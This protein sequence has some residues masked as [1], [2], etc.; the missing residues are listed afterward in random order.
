LI[1]VTLVGA[2]LLS[3]SI[4]PRPASASS[5]FAFNWQGSPASPRPWTPGQVNDWDLITNIAGSTDQARNPIA[6][7]GPDCSA[8]PAL[9]S[10]TN[11]ADTAFIC[12]DHMMTAISSEFDGP[13]GAIYWAPAQLADFS[14]G[15]STI[16]WQVSTLRRGERMWWDLWLTPF[17]E[18][19]VVPLQQLPAYQGPPKDAVHIQLDGTSCQNPSLIQSSALRVNVYSNFHSTDVTDAFPCLEDA[20]PTSAVTRTPFE[21]DVSRNHLKVWVPG[22]SLVYKDS[23]ISL[24]FNKAVVQWGHHSYGP[25]KGCNVPAP[26]ADTFHW[27]NV[28]ISPAAPFTMLR[29]DQPH[30]LHDGQNPTL[31][32]PQPAPANAFLRFAALLPISVSFD[33]GSMQPAKRQQQMGPDSD[34]VLHPEQFYSYWMPI[35]AGTKT[36]R[37]TGADHEAW[38]Y[39]SWWVED[40]SVWSETGSG[41][42]TSTPTASPSPAPSPSS[43][44]T[45][46]PPSC[47]TPTPA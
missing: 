30:S 7:H 8:P 31:T 11:L 47:G 42:P 38:Y 22:T 44:P 13:Y 3:T 12:K 17:S 43:T 37:F 16:T 35:P 25:D 9:H 40:V 28:S 33:G 21:V 4:P 23:S 10:I 36:L 19:L 29:P 46:T 41:G 2:P 39:D 45:A 1:A 18:N 32:L 20:L 24:P 34:G 5:S 15:T 6:Q 27:S 14:A 26:C